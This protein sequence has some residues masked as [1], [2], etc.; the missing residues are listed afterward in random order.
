MD[1]A[2]P[3]MNDSVPLPVV[4]S[5]NNFAVTLADC[6]N[7][8]GYLENL[9]SPTAP[10]TGELRNSLQRNEILRKQIKG[11]WHILPPA[12]LLKPRRVRTEKR[13]SGNHAEKK[14]SGSRNTSCLQMPLG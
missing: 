4:V 2:R 14:R 13:T 12:Q 3:R 11:Y 5:S 9:V 8:Q 1:V 10:L 6:R 7:G